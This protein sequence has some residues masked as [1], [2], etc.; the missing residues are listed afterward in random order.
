MGKLLKV[1][2]GAAALFGMAMLAGC[3]DDFSDSSKMQFTTVMA[4]ANEVPPKTVDGTGKGWFALDKSTKVLK[5]KVT[6][7]DLTGPPVAMHFHGPSNINISAPVVLPMPLPPTPASPLTGQATLT[8]AQI[9]DLSAGKWYVNTHTAK[10]KDGE[11]R[12]QVMPA[13]K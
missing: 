5:W 8:D 10:H 13:G 2:I 6:Y 4:G 9:A 7:E 1:M 11:I 3:A 12:G